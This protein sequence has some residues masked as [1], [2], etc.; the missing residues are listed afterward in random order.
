MRTDDRFVDVSEQ[1]E[2]CDTALGCS[3]DVVCA[4]QGRALRYGKAQAF[5]S[6]EVRLRLQAPP[7]SMARFR[8]GGFASFAIAQARSRQK[9]D[10]S[11]WSALAD[12]PVPS[13]A[14]LRQLF[15][16]TP[17]EARLAQGLAR[18]EALEEVADELKIKMTTAR[19]QL[20]T[21]FGK[22][23]TRRQAGL[24]AI[25]SRLAHLDEVHQD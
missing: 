11:S 23:Q 3:D 17:A 20:A 5:P 2:P 24:V 16:L 19:S 10:A 15:D 22:T 25:L 7:V 4:P 12:L 9:A 18:G 14:R 8:A 1:V 21:I 13:E 6:P